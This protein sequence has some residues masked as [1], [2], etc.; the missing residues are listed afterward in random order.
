MD[1][2]LAYV[3]Y[4]VIVAGLLGTFGLIYSLLAGLVTRLNQHSSTL[5]HHHYR[6]SHVER[7]A[8]VAPITSPHNDNP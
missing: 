1:S 8:G 4:P 5:G 2:F 3:I 6:L 7:A